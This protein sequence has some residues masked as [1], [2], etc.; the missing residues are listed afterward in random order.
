MKVSKGRQTSND[1]KNTNKL[2][3]NVSQ[4]SKPNNNNKANAIF[5][6]RMIQ[7][8]IKVNNP[9]KENISKNYIATEEST[10]NKRKNSTNRVSWEKEQAEKARKQKANAKPQARNCMLARPI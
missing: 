5:S 9:K 8:S 2:S 3:V 6:N 1:S 10:K 4:Q 7:Q